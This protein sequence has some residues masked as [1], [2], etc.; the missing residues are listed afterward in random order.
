MAL[1]PPTEESNALSIRLDALDAVGFVRTLRGVDAQVFA[2]W[3]EHEGLLDPGPLAAAEATTQAAV[4]TLAAGGVVAITGCGTSGRVAHLVAR[5]LSRLLQDERGTLVGGAAD[6]LISGGD[7]ALLLS[8]ELP[9]DDPAAG[10]QQLSELANTRPACL[11]IGVSCGLSAPYVAGQL[12]HAISAGWSATALGFNPA[13]L[14][15]D[16]P[17]DGLSCGGSFRDI[18]AALANPGA[19][20]TT[21]GKRGGGR[22]ALLNPVV[23]PEAVAGSS[24]MKGGT[25]TLILAD[26]ICYRASRLLRGQSA[27]PISAALG[28]ASDAARLT[29]AEATSIAT[30][31]EL[32][33][34]AMRSGGRL[35]YL[36]EGS[37]GVLGCIDAS[38]MPDTYGVPFDAVRGF[39]CGGWADVANREGDLASRSHLLRISLEHF[40][41]D[42]LP[43]LTPADAVVLLGCSV[44]PRAEAPTSSEE[45]FDGLCS[46]RLW[47]AVKRLRT[48]GVGSISLLAAAR[49]ADEA[50]GLR[51]CASTAKLD[52][53]T[54][55][56]L[57]AAGLGPGHGALAELSLKLMLNNVS[58]FAMTARG[59]VYKNRMISTS[60]TNDKI[61]HRC[62]RMIA[63]LAGVD[64]SV[65][66]TA[67]LR[68][69]YRVD[70]LA[71]DLTSA[72]TAAHIVAAT[73]QGDAQL[74]QQLVLP[75][76]ILLA[77]SPSSSVA[78]AAEA[79]R[80]EP[81]VSVLLR[82][83]LRGEAATSETPA[84]AAMPA[85]GP[86]GSCV[87]GLDCGATSIKSAVVRSSSA[88]LVGTVQRQILE[89]RDFEKVVAELC[90]TAHASASSAGVPWESV[91]AVSLSQPGHVDASTGRVAAAANFPSWVDVPFREKLE[92]QLGKPVTLL[93]D[94]DAAMLAELRPNGAAAFDATSAAAAASLAADAAAHTAALLV[95]GGGVGS[96]LAIGGRVHRGASGMIEAGHMIVERGGRACGCGQ[97]GCLEAYASGTAIARRAAELA[98]QA[99]P[100]AGA[101][102]PPLEARHV[103]EAAANGDATAMQAVGEAAGALAT[104]CVN[105]C[106]TCDP[107]AIVIAGGLAT[108]QLLTQV[109]AKFDALAWSIL[110]NRVQIRLATAGADA[111][112]LGAAAAALASLPSHCEASLV[113][114]GEDKSERFLVRRATSDD[115]AAALRV[116][117]LTGNAGAD[118]TDTYPHDP[119]ALGKRWVAPY[120]DLEPAFA[121]VLEE[122]ATKEVVGY[123]L[124]ALNTAAFA[125]RMQA[126]Y[127]PPLRAVHPDPSIS[128]VP[129]AEW[130]AEQV[131]YQELHDP[132]AGASPPGLDPSAYPSHL[133]IDLTPRAQGCGQ[134]VRMMSAQLNAL[135]AAGSAGVY[136]QMHESNTRARRFYAKLGFEELAV[137]GDAASGGGTGGDLHLGL[138]LQ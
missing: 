33:A 98:A 70:A 85:A 16:T 65:A 14:A 21:N 136:L 134:G 48:A 77:A 7:A 22:H 25:A 97:L 42:V 95:L 35:L 18:T 13:E 88:E 124:A 120:L 117:L 30:V 47:A 137:G 23:G 73:P 72:P 111:G 66:K 44:E 99:S 51:K 56:P 113:P 64:E 57:A 132:T 69:I 53:F 62:V 3:R 61:Y 129:E 102:Q 81:R 119:D 41:T 108:P 82:S 15:R 104:A 116:C 52:A 105:I 6:Y 90:A 27:L 128:G 127:L 36:G 80:C 74:K 67:L 122:T 79:L 135:R 59:L 94:A 63:E 125:E 110:P 87:I 75:L 10:A 8:D 39:V 38:E 11:L 118:A 71:P 92:A 78:A 126:E 96:S 40:D 68:A 12:D 101:A 60:P 138:K 112:A 100:A 9:E 31:C 123:C 91:A 106:R 133:H 49:G 58:T 1:L 4:A 83:Q 107:H 34:R 20:T 32:A 37:A 19:T 130:T 29:Y 43:T 17:V 45:N 50:D 121:L 103:F 54:V 115:R 76:A 93:E 24:R 84:N 114:S 86:S 131:A 26:A 55:V 89:S 109:R 5:R 46:D 28:A 2:G